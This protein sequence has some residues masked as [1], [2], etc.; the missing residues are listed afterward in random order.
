MELCTLYIDIQTKEK[1]LSS[2][3]WRL[4]NTR[5]VPVMPIAKCFRGGSA[6]SPIPPV[7]APW[8]ADD[9]STIKSR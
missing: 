3:P 6:R 7:Y 9:I 4:G 1:V 8:T 2:K 5:K